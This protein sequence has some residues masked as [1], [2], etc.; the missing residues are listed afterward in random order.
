MEDDF[1]SVR[2]TNRDHLSEDAYDK[3]LGHF[4]RRY[5]RYQLVK[6]Y[7][8]FGAEVIPDEDYCP[9]EYLD[10]RRE[11]NMRTM[12]QNRLLRRFTQSEKRK[13][14]CQAMQEIIKYYMEAPDNQ[15]EDLAD[16]INREARREYD[17]ARRKEMLQSGNFDWLIDNY[18]SGLLDMGNMADMSLL[19]RLEVEIYSTFMNG[20]EDMQDDKRVAPVNFLM[21]AE[22]RRDFINQIINN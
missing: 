6:Q 11:T 5:H 20:E 2:G 8:A 1:K 9:K 12:E 21:E 15:F 14:E 10:Y 13:A 16:A 19:K 4:R 17:I 7:D 3:A 18:N 22:N